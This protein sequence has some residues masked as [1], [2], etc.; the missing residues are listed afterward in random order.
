MPTQL[1][2]ALRKGLTEAMRETTGSGAKSGAEYGRQERRPPTTQIRSTA[3]TAVSRKFRNRYLTLP[4]LDKAP[5]RNYIL[6]S[7]C[8]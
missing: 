3:P 6:L 2:H 4:G 8:D 5:V 7:R 1:R